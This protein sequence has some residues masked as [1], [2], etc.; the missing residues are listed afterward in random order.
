MTRS[1]RDAAC[2]ER[3]VLIIIPVYNDWE[4]LALLS[5]RLDE[6]LP[7]GGPAVEVLVVDDGSSLPSPALSL[8]LK[9]I[10]RID[11]LELRRNLGHQRAIAI[12]LAYVEAHRPCSAVVVMDADGE[13]APEDVPRLIDRC[14]AEG[15][16]KL[17]FAQR[18][19]RSE[20]AAFRAF[21]FLYR[22]FYRMLT[23][24]PIRMGN[25]SIIPFDILH[26]VVA[27]SEI[28]SHY[29]AGILKARV[30][31]VEIDTERQRRLAGHP[32]MDFVS[33]VTHGLGAISVHGEV[34]G[35]RL[36][37]AAALLVVA[38]LV[39]IGVVIGIRLFTT[40]AIPGWATY[41]VASLL[42]L[43]VQALALS[44]LFVFVILGSRNS[45]SFL[46]MRDYVHFILRVRAVERA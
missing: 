26:R 37:V 17:V 25:F 33:L 35:V 11:V 43:V 28:W 45:Y 29:A 13:D 32:K 19:R 23:G 20:S 4:S 31:H 30:E 36:M 18:A 10:C 6:A 14:A 9:K 38:S 8:Q 34:A 12:G 15:W 40:L 27:V 1:E 41:A 21:Y 44:L 24:Q 46:P 42:I 39:G 2:S 16:R 3:T 5:N 22:S 7:A